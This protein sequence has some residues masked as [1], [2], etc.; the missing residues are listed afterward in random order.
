M[1]NPLQPPEPEDY[2]QDWPRTIAEAVDRLL[3]TL[4][5]DEKGEIAAMPEGDLLNLH[6]GL[7]TS[8]RNKF[9]LWRENHTLLKECQKIR[10]EGRVDVPDGL[11]LIDPDDASTIIIKALWGNLR[12]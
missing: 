6:F 10:F 8:V 3:L 7:G 1:T 11:I 2:G 12:H 5:Q 9:G 4:S